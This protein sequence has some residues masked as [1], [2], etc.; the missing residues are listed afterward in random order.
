MRTMN[1][2]VHRED[3][4]SSHTSMGI[5]GLFLA[6]PGLI[7]LWCKM[8]LYQPDYIMVRLAGAMLI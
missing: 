7:S 2:D 8:C 6:L 4:I 3:L 5:R 1:A